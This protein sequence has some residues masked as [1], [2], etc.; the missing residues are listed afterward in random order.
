NCLFYLELLSLGADVVVTRL[1]K[2][3][4]INALDNARYI[5]NKEVPE[6]LYREMIES[7]SNLAKVKVVNTLESELEQ[8][9]NAIKKLGI[10]IKVHNNK[11]G[12]SQS[13]H[14]LQLII[15]NIKNMKKNSHTEKAALKKEGIISPKTQKCVG[16]CVDFAKSK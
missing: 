16:V 15:K 5:P 10:E 12:A 9:D 6:E 3:S 7:L 11:L 2:K 4:A 13:A 1:L 14:K 8:I